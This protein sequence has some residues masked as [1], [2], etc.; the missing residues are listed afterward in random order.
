MSILKKRVFVTRKIPS[1]GLDIINQEFHT[2][3]WPDEFPPS[4]EEIVDMAT[5]C[6]G[7]V[8]LLSDPIGAD[9]IDHLPNLKVIAQFAVGY[10]NI[11]V[12]YATQKGIIVTN[13]PGVL[14]E[15]TADLT[16][17][18]IMSASRRIVEADR[19]VREGHWK[20]AWGPELL[21]GSDVFGA[22]IGIVGMGRIGRA[23]ARRAAGFNMKI[24]YTAR[25]VQERD[26]EVA[27][28][29]GAQRVD[30]KTLLRASEIVT[31]HVPLTSDTTNLIGKPELAM[32]KPGSILIN[33]SRGP[34]VDE[35]ALYQALLTKQL[36]AAGLD[37]F[38]EEPIRLDSPLLQLAN[39]VLAPHIGSA[40]TRTRSTMAKMCAENL[41]VALSGAKP[42]NIVNPEVL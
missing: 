26:S 11:D 39:I 21:L 22:T 38:T 42:T 32:M 8:T 5:D 12:K 25:S 9:V 36:G 40:S 20:V 23:V 6:E 7:M 30:L 14:T 41:H 10:D 27:E 15:T 1:E 35:D 13:T 33:T 24:L 4:K 2:S 3:V 18:L 28:Q 37:V 19:Y 34:V 16:W 29:L 17:A 31:L